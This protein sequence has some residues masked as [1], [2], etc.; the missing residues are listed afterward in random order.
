MVEVDTLE[1]TKRGED[2]FFLMG[3]TK[4]LQLEKLEEAAEE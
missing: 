3:K 1:I 2:S 4:E